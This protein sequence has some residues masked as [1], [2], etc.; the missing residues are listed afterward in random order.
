MYPGPILM[1]FSQNIGYHILFLKLP[2]ENITMRTKKIQTVLAGLLLVLVLF[3]FG[4]TLDYNIIMPGVLNFS[5][6]N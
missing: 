3:Y 5:A 2:E 4:N 1:K 6:C